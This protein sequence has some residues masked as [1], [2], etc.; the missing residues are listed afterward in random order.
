[1]LAKIPKEQLKKTDRLNYTC[2]LQVK[3]KYNV[4]SKPPLFFILKIIVKNK[5]EIRYKKLG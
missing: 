3:I 2:K 5:K 4:Q 1:M